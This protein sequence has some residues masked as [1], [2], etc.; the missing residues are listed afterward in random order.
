[1]RGEVKMPRT[2]KNPQQLFTESLK[3]ARLIARDGIVKSSDLDRKFREKLIAESC[4]MEIIKGWYLLTPPGGEGEST[5][6]FGGFWPFLKYYLSERFGKAGFCLS[7][8]SSLNVHAGNTAIPKQIKVLTKKASNKSITLPH[9]TSILL[10]MDAN[11]FPEDPEEW[12]G[13]RI[14]SLPSAL[15]RL[16]PIYYQKN[17]G[18]IEVVLKISS[19]SVSEI[20]R[21]IF[22]TGAIASAERIIGAYRHLGEEA[23]ANQIQEDLITAGYQV[24]EVNPFIE[25]EPKL[26]STLSA[27]PYAGRIRMMWNAMRDEV[28]NIMPASPG[29]TGN[30][31]KA[32]KSI[33]ERY[34]E[35]AYHS[36]SI[37]GYQVTEELIE[38][39]QSGEWDPDNVDADRRQKDAL[40][41]KGYQAAFKAV[42]QSISRVLDGERAGKVFEEDLQTWYR[43]LFAPLLKANILS[44]EN[45]VGYRNQPVYISGSRHVPPP[46]SAVPDCMEALFDLLKE[47]KNAA[48]RAVLGHFIFVFI[49]PY[50]DGNGRVGRFLMNLMLVS[51]GFNWTVI[52]ADKRDEYMTSLEKASTEEKIK[53]FVEFIKKFLA[54]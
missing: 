8:E 33:Q 38:K 23:K 1:M 20:S 41:A 2:R 44:A 4:L 36:L 19:L 9:D 46:W 45:L 26:G 12:N 39:I 31:Q 29:V 6:W 28:L 51:G 22:H 47:E 34:R 35:D 53:P 30:V 21:N 24:K 49:H 5:A 10:L 15:C 32:L 13:V 50:M 17:P 27:S 18:N 42:L 7:A 43:Q 48:V 3:E 40:A 37:E 11:N 54:S 16:A 14:M 25:Y 52:K